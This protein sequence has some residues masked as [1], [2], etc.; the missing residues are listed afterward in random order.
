MALLLQLGFRL[1]LL[2]GSFGFAKTLAVF[3]R[4]LRFDLAG[5][6]FAA[7]AQIYNI[8]HFLIIYKI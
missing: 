7:V 6:L 8:G 2:A 4:L 1:A 5:L 3:S